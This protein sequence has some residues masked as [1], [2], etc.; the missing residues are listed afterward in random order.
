ME[1]RGKAQR[2]AELEGSDMEFNETP[3]EVW[4]AVVQVQPAADATE[5]D[6]AGAP[7]LTFV[8][9]HVKRKA[10][11][12]NTLTLSRGAVLAA[13]AGA[14][15]QDQEGGGDGRNVTALLPPP[16]GYEEDAL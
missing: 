4:E 12:Q 11:Y 7:A 8:P 1:V 6:G 10:S 3:L 14:A 9:L 2:P 5:G 13:L 16:H 15:A